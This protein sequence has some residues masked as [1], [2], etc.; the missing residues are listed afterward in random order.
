MKTLLKILGG[1]L[2]GIVAGLVIAAV[3]IVLFTD[4]TFS[5]FIE[6]MQSTAGTEILLSAAV[7]M[8]SFLIS[9]VILIPVHEGGHLVCG[10][11]TGYKFVSFRIFNLTFIKVNN[12]LKVKRIFSGRHRRTMPSVATRHGDGQGAGSMV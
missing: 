3:M 5:E 10:L 8:V 9:V 2:I 1:L 4:Q 11:L 12:R 6:N 7:A